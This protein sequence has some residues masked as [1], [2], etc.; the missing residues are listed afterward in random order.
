VKKITFQQ[1]TQTGLENIGKT[2][3][4]MAE[5]EGLLAHA[6]AVRVR[7]SSI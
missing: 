7:L 3:I 5:K 6:N 4:T 1:L 2:V